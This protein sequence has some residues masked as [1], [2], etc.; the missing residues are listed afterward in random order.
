MAG[1]GSCSCAVCAG[2]ADLQY[3]GEA[4]Q[5][6]SSG[7][8]VWSLDQIL[9]NLMRWDGR[10][11]APLSIP[12]SFY[13]V[14]PAHLTNAP[15]YQGFVAFD[16]AQ[17]QATRTALEVISDVANLKFVE[18]PDDGLDPGPAVARLTY[19]RGNWGHANATASASVDISPTL[20]LGDAREIHAAEISFNTQRWGGQALPA[21]REFYVILHETMHALG[22]PHPGQYNNVGGAVITYA[23]NAEYA[24]DTHQY[25]VLSYFGAQET[26]GD[27]KG[28][29]AS[30]L[31]LHDIAALQALYGPNMAA[32]TGDTTYGFGS[33]AG[34]SV[35]D[36]AV[37]TRPVMSI[38][39]AGGIDTINLSGFSQAARLDL[40]AGAFS[41]I[42]GMIGNLSIAFG[43][44]IENAVAGMFADVVTGNAAGNHV[45]AG[46]GDDRVDGRAG[47]DVLFGN[48]GS[49][50]LDGGEGNDTLYGGRDADHVFGGN[51]ADFVQGDLGDDRVE[52]GAGADVLSGGHDQDRLDGGDDRD[53]VFG[54]DGDDTLDGG[55]GADFVAGDDGADLITNAGGVDLI[56]GGAGNDTL[57]AGADGDCLLGN[58][59]D[60]RLIG[61]AGV[62][63]LF[64]GR[65]NDTL[66]GGAGDDW[67]SGD[68]G[69]DVLTG[70]AG[71]DRFV[72]TAIDGAVDRI[73]DFAPL[74]DFLD[75]TAID[76]DAGQAG[77]QA[78]ALVSAFTGQAGQ[79]VLSYD[80]TSTT[81]RGDVN[82]D[83]VSDFDLLIDGQVTSTDGWL[84]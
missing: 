43:V 77:D 58:Q 44:L 69:A 64:G 60:D 74:V 19:A 15:L 61:G 22:F 30:T 14:R 55:A 1:H 52:G 50:T 41:D 40:N 47:D 67:L 75:L 7:K 4:S 28:A 57:V 35:Y 26:G 72:F 53:L 3:A 59:D 63:T 80:G 20:L 70:G 73:T 17:R 6:Q 48:Q 78:F 62:D 11:E 18:V 5:A 84:L 45:L 37:N 66:E 68:L 51:G 25:T 33:N 81:V 65:G 24:Q 36:F 29:F 83:G 56:F 8:P 54:G 38:W 21:S 13:D 34:S 2:E 31:M 39:D 82:G 12:F 16:E 79:L 9:A 10:W 46:A 23:Q 32:R 42:A 76:A 49:D 71:R 27:F